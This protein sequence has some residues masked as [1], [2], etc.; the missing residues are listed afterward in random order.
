[1]PPIGATL[2]A[3]RRRHGRSLAD[4]A[5]STRIRESYLAALE[6]EDFGVLGGDVYARGF[7]RSYARYLELDP[8]PLL[9]TYR[10]VH[11]RPDEVGMLPPG[12]AI[13]SMLP[14]AD[15][16]RPPRGLV[17]AA[18]AVAL[19][20]VL[21]VVVLRGD[22]AADSPGGPEPVAGSSDPLAR[23]MALRSEAMAQPAGEP[24]AGDAPAGAGAAPSTGAPA[25]GVDGA[26][27]MTGPIEVALT[28]VAGPVR[29]RVVQ[30]QPPVDAT[31]QQGDQRIVSDA[32]GIVVEVADA[33][34]LQVSVNG[35]PLPA[36]GRAGERVVVTCLVGEVACEVALA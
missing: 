18:V 30:G 11:E 13:D 12:A 7:L 31:L 10:E 2:R 27:P 23:A 17:L 33:A 6:D 29:V 36:L 1:M 14:D 20:V 34:A 21:G 32:E 9:A 25:P 28:V 24:G 4:A 19:L 22:D 5:A 15:R 8:D 3:A 26:Q 16:T 35:A